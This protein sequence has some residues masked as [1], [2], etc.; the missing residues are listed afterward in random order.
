MND[1]RKQSPHYIPELDPEKNSSDYGA[2]D[3]AKYFV[4]MFLMSGIFLILFGKVAERNNATFFG[5]F[6]LIFGL[7][8][9]ALLFF[10][11]NKRSEK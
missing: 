6:M 3:I 7:V 4:L 11:T 8:G 10:R 9:L 2:R 1:E 5:A